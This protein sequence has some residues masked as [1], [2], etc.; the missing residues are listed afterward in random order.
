MG[1]S[2]PYFTCFLWTDTEEQSRPTVE[3][4]IRAQLTEQLVI[5]QRKQFWHPFGCTRTKIFR[6]QG[7]S[8]SGPQRRALCSLFAYSKQNTWIRFWPIVYHLS[9]LCPPFNKWIHLVRILY[10]NFVSYYTTATLSPDGCPSCQDTSYLSSDA[11][12]KGRNVK[13]FIIMVV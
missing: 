5:R 3:T 11:S 1:G 10:Y 6:L 13:V 4:T 12:E 2:R 9:G 8:T 7:A